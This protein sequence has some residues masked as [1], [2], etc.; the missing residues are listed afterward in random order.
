MY[1]ASDVTGD[2]EGIFG[3]ESTL[4]RAYGSKRAVFERGKT[5]ARSIDDGVAISTNRRK[6]LAGLAGAIVWLMPLCIADAESIPL[7]SE[8]GVWTVPVRVNDTVTLPF[9]VDSGA[10]DVSITYDLYLIL[11][12]AGSVSSADITGYTSY[13]LADGSTQREPNLRIRSL[14]IG[15]I[16]LRDVDCSVAPERGSLLL[17]QSFLSRFKTVSIDYQRHVL[18][19][20][21]SPTAPNSPAIRETSAS[22]ASPVY[23]PAPPLPVRD[24]NDPDH[25]CGAAQT[26]CRDG[27]YLCSVY[28]QDLVRAGR[29]CAGV[30]DTAYP[31]SAQPN[32]ENDPDYSCRAAQSF[33]RDGAPL[34][35]VY[36][37]DFR[38]AGRICPGVTMPAE[39]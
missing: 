21:E 29:V 3:I 27:M 28:R 39:H 16:E 26:F 12:R 23:S 9:V 15:G 7:N 32:D 20:N 30:T 24:D 1:S 17:G 18:L 34:C 11:R 10:A 19:L 14:R 31:A 8:G 25:A 33:C 2:C 4:P 6:L 13:S 38:R 5:A 22:P 37:R 36:R 35:D